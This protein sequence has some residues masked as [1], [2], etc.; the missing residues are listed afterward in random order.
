MCRRANR[1]GEM[2]RRFVHW[3]AAASTFAGI[4]GAGV[5]DGLLVLTRSSDARAGEVATLS[6]GLYGVAALAIG[7]L[8]GWMART[9]IDAIPG[10]QGAA[11]L[12]EAQTDD[13]VATA[14]VAGL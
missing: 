10:G 9:A 3:P 6:L 8:L 4:F 11:G 1:V 13:G 5:V 14:L 7:A 12:R 2:N